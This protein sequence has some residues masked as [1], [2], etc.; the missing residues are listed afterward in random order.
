PAPSFALI[1]ALTCAAAASRAARVTAVARA[2]AAGR[3]EAAGGAIEADGREA[4]GGGAAPGH[5]GGAHA[6]WTAGAAK[7]ARSPRIRAACI[8][9][10]IGGR[11][12][13]VHEKPSLVRR[14][15]GHRRGR[16]DRRPGEPHGRARPDEATRSVVVLHRDEIA[17][18]REAVRHVVE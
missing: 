17:A 10:V 8:G 1:R 18:P 6:R 4:G 2:P 9:P 14:R 11:S 7:T 3:A 15:R 12:A 5:F 16:R 13:R